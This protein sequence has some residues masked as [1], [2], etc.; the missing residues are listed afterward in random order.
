[1]DS[2][3]VDTAMIDS[4]AIDTMDNIIAE[5]PMPKAA[6]ELFDDFIFNF[7]ANKKLQFERINFPLPVY[8]DNK[9]EQIKRNQWTMEHFFM[10]QEFYTLIFDNAKQ[11]KVVKDTTIDHVVIEKIFFKKKTIKEYVFNR[12]NGQWRLINIAYKGMHKN[13]NAS[14]LNFYYKFVTDS[15]F[16]INSVHNPLQFSGPDPDDDFGIMNG[17][18]EPEQWSSFA[19]QL[20]SNYIYNILYG[21]SYKE[22]RE[23]VFVIRGIANGLETELTFKYLGNSWKLIKLSM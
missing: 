13:L 10:R 4:S 7:A 3:V 19:P 20:P 9:V 15:T 11:M 6:D 18:L 2:V 23:K 17:T 5:T 21:Q 8:H 16:Q 22:S 1:M 12:I 14:F